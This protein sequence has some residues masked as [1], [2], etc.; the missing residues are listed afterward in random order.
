MEGPQ[1][2][3]PTRRITRRRRSDPIEII[4]GCRVIV[5]ARWP[6]V[7]EIPDPSLAFLLFV[8]VVPVVILWLAKAVAV[9]SGAYIDEMNVR[10]VH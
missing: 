4:G 1:N 3:S 7:V 5:Y 2:L 8:L 6:E 10:V 9:E